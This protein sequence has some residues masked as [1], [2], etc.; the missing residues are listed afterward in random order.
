MTS[1]P[2]W[3]T[4]EVPALAPLP[5]LLVPVATAVA[6]ASVTFWMPVTLGLVPE[7]LAST[8]FAAEMAKLVPAVPL[9]VPPAST[10][11]AVSF[12]SAKLVLTRVSNVKLWML[13]PSFT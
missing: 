2:Y 11:V 5:V 6:L 4:M 8:P 1:V 10:A 9:A 12:T 13:L 7:S 3:P